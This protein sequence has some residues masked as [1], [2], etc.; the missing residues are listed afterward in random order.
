M[1]L[2]S[3]ENTSSWRSKPIPRAAALTGI[4]ASIILP[5]A[6]WLHWQQER[7]PTVTPAVTTPVP[8]VPA[9]LPDSLP[10]E[11][12][13]VVDAV[14]SPPAGTELP[15]GMLSNPPAA[16]EGPTASLPATAAD[17]PVPVAS[18]RQANAAGLS[19]APVPAFK[20]TSPQ[21]KADNLYRQAIGK[22]QQSQSDLARQTLQQALA[23]YPAHHEARQAL[24]VLM[25]EAG[26]D[27]AATALMKEGL[28]LAPG[29]SGFSMLMARLQVNAGNR[30]QAIATLE[31][32]LALAGE[33]GEYHAFLALLLQG[34]DRHEQAIRH[35]IAALRTDPA[36]PRWLIG[37][38]ISL[39]NQGLLGDAAAA[40]ERA[41]ETGRLLPEQAEFARRSLQQIRQR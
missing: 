33:D 22:L 40:F 12:Q 19:A 29:H 41:L 25:A 39:Q 26:E 36:E 27:R 14:R 5:G 16:V 15:G 6:A 8:S 35:F 28:A 20:S 3:R 10:A 23:S 37:T 2:N 30:Q 13:Q 17:S 7:T 1:T 31:Q 38:G 11:P 34:Q 4:A 32:G 18:E 24:A 21:Q 9:P